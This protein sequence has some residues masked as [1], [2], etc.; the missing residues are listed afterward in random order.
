MPQE[1]FWYDPP[2]SRRYFAVANRFR[3]RIATFFLL[4]L[5]NCPK[6]RY[7]T[8]CDDWTKTHNA[9]H[10]SSPSFGLNSL[11]LLCQFLILL[12]YLSFLVAAIFF[13]LYLLCRFDEVILWAVYAVWDPIFFCVSYV[14]FTVVVLLIESVI[15][16]KYW[17]L[18]APNLMPRS[19][20]KHPINRSLIRGL[21]AAKGSLFNR[22]YMFQTFPWN[23]FWH[24]CHEVTAR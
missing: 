23:I 22:F 19:E 7:A 20:L 4:L 1:D 21:R 18:M 11:A 8:G 14:L 13:R 9:C 15:F 24:C 10:V 3:T 16:L 6:K 2:C 17:W 5:C 12:C